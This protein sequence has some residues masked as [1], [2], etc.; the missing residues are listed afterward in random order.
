MINGW[1]AD[2]IRFDMD[3][4]FYNYVDVEEVN[5]FTTTE[6]YL[7][8]IRKEIMADEEENDPLDIKGFDYD[9]YD[10]NYI[11]RDIVNKMMKKEVVDTRKLA[12]DDGKKPKKGTDLQMK[13]ELRHQAV[14]M[15]REKRNQE[16]ESK[17]RERLE[18]K[19]IELKARQMVEK[20]ERDKL[21]K[22]NIEQQLI[23]QEVERLRLEM[24][25]QR[26]ADE[27]I[28]RKYVFKYRIKFDNFDKIF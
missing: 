25:E 3:D 12:L 7:D 18:K 28:R 16:V 8:K 15:N 22:Q 21:A 9:K 4:D 17:R 26:R 23:D 19:E 1:V 5:K 13:I 14:K 11:A 2:K 10:E 24:A 27:E 20:E 6:K